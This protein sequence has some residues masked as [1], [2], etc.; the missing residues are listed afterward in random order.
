MEAGTLIPPS[1]GNPRRMMA[2]LL[3]RQRRGLAQYANRAPGIT[4]RSTPTTGCLEANPFTAPCTRTW[5]TS[6]CITRCALG[7]VAT[8][9]HT[10]ATPAARPYTVSRTRTLVS[11]L[12]LSGGNGSSPAVL[13]A[14]VWLRAASK[15]SWS[16]YSSASERAGEY[17]NSIISIHGLLGYYCLHL[18]NGRPTTALLVVRKRCCVARPRRLGPRGPRISEP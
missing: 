15:C 6:T 17:H 2:A 13:P 12:R 10:T 3:L 14:C 1:L 9:G 8:R 16:A 18:S 4:A 5:D 11:V 7:R